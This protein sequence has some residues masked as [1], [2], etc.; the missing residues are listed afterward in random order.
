MGNQMVLTASVIAAAFSLAIAAFGAALAQ[1]KVASSAVEGIAR[2][3]EARG[4]IMQ[5]L[6]LSLAFIESL[7]L[8]VLLISIVLIFANPFK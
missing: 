8:Y 3:P 7:T 1:G 6:I 2:Q 4:A 5:A